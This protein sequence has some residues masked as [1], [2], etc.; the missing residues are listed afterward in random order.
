MLW[1]L[2]CLNEAILDEF[3]SF[4]V[5]WNPFKKR[6][7]LLHLAARFNIDRP[8]RVER[9]WRS[10]RPAGNNGCEC[11]IL[12]GISKLRRTAVFHDRLFL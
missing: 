11:P 7:F 8:V 6:F 10:H 9:S 3:Y 12:T 5:I 4:D 2:I 1:R